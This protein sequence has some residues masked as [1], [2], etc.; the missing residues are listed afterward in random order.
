M[1]LVLFTMCV[2]YPIFAVVILFAVSK[3]IHVSTVV[4]ADGLAH[5]EV[6]TRL[7]LGICKGD[8]A[9]CRWFWFQIVGAALL[10]PVLAF[11]A[12]LVYYRKKLFVDRFVNDHI[13]SLSKQI[14]SFSSF[15]LDIQSIKQ[16]RE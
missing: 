2:I 4:D 10:L 13:T 14:I 11:A 6:V 7:P 16:M 15:V 1:P 8:P 9:H 3:N 12:Q 5:D